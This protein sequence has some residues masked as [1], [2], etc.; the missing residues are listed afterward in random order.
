LKI[1]ILGSQGF[2]G[3]HLTKFF[4]DQKQKVYGCDLIDFNTNDFIYTKISVLDSAFELFISNNSF[5]ICINASGNGNVSVSFEDPIFDF[6]SNVVVVDKILFFLTKYQPTCKFIHLSSAAVYGNPVLLPVSEESALQP[7]SPYGYN[8]LLSEIVCQKYFNLFSIPIV[9]LRPFSV[10]GNRLKK[11]IIWDVCSKIRDSD[12]IEM[13]GTGAESRDF[14]HISDVLQCIDLLIKHADF[15]AEVYNIANGDEVSIKELLALIT[16]H[17]PTKKVV[18]TSTTRIG[19][20][21]NWRADI[22]KLCLLGYKRSIP[23]V[24]GIEQYISW[25]NNQFQIDTK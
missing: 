18:F 22:T 19:D 6:N 21:L 5:D 3:S 7:Q 20:P 17:Y 25:F 23:L 15:N 10:Y 24:E 1:L 14:I 8:K 13:F 16:T 11:Q 9:I 2:I 12:S 4:C